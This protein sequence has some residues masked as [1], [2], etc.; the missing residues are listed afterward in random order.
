MSEDIATKWLDGLAAPSAEEL[1]AAAGPQQGRP[2][3]ILSLPPEQHVLLLAAHSWAHEPLR[4]LRDLV[5][6]ALVAA[7][8]DR[9]AT[10]ELARRWGIDRL[11]RTTEAAADWLGGDGEMPRVQ[12]LW[13]R[14]LGTARERTVLESHVERL[15]SDFWAR[16]PSESLRRLPANVLRALRPEE[17]EPWS[18][19]LRR[20]VW[21]SMMSSSVCS[22]AAKSSIVSVSTAWLSTV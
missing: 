22:M 1:L 8:T 3:T 12:R 19:K 2:A 13:A 6:V 20:V 9:E 11:W 14:N 5:D 21:L 4:R 17:A 10:R 7:E 16:R 18:A 15:T